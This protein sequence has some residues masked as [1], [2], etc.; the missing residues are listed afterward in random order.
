MNGKINEFLIKNGS[1]GT[2]WQ[3]AGL[4]RAIEDIIDSDIVPDSDKIQQMM[5]DASK[6]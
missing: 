2:E 1:R 3:E 6:F 4:L 5:K